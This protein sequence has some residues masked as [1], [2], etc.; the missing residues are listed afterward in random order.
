MTPETRAMKLV[1]LFLL[2]GGLLGLVTVVVAVI[3]NFF[4][5]RA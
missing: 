4:S 1:S 5:L 3:G 2:I